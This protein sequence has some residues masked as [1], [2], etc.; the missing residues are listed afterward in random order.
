M[1][2]QCPNKSNKVFAYKLCV[3]LYCVVMLS[4]TFYSCWCQF[5]V[6]TWELSPQKCDCGKSL[7]SPQSDECKQPNTREIILPEIPSFS[8]AALSCAGSP[9]LLHWKLMNWRLTGFFML[10]FLFLDPKEISRLFRMTN[11]LPYSL[12]CRGSMSLILWDYDLDNCSLMHIAFAVRIT[13]VSY[14]PA[15]KRMQVHS[16]VCQIQKPIIHTYVLRVYSSFSAT[17]ET[18]KKW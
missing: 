12:C 8:Q 15:P 16:T 18:S 13:V 2:I 4:I 11:L 14:E 9:I 7:W 1:C 3:T 17:N 10:R 5:F 6:P